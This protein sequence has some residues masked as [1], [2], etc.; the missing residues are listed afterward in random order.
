MKNNEFV[1]GKNQVVL[2]GF[3]LETW[4]SNSE[5]QRADHYAMCASVFENRLS[6]LHARVT[7]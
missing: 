2:P 3:E 4:T 1:K 5:D 6:G 7:L